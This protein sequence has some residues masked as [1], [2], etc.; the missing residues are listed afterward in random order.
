M[1]PFLKPKIQTGIVIQKTRASDGEPAEMTEESGD[2]Q[3]MVA[4]AEDILRAVST[5][6]AVLLAKA[7]KAAFDIYE[8][9]PHEEADHSYDAQNMKAAKQERE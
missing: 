7:I 4:A 5:K 2:D 1:L 6:D 8:A 3:D 9:Q